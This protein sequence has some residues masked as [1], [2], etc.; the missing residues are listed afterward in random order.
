MASFIIR[1]NIERL[2]DAGG[3]DLPADYRNRKALNA[4]GAAGADGPAAGG[5]VSAALAPRGHGIGVSRF[6]FH[7]QVYRADASACTCRRATYDVT[8][9]RGPEYLSHTRTIT[10]PEGVAE[11]TETFQL[12]RWIHMK[13][14]GFTAWT[15]V[16][17]GGCTLRESGS[18][19]RPE[20]MLR[21]AMGE[22]L[23]VAS[24]LSGAR[25]GITRRRS[26]RARS[27][28]LHGGKPDPV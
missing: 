1:D 24:V 7:P 11:H 26:S 9:T 13:E 28:R 3:G 20:A 4:V 2:A 16:H 27:T 15:H 17:G 10:V 22:D 23:N 6:L 25:A 21:Q 12:E 19:L 8:W 18:R 14:K 5:G